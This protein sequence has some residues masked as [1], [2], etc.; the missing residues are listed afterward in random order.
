[1]AYAK[2]SAPRR[3][4]ILTQFL[5]EA[6]MVTALGE[7]WSDDRLGLAYLIGRVDRLS[8]LVSVASACW[9]RVSS[10]V[11]TSAGSGRWRAARLVRL[12]H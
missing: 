5:I 6:V 2:P 8:A 7:L 9:R 11:G 4:D 10:V 3:K 1:L 12:K